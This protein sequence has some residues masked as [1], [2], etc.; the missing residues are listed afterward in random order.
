MQGRGPVGVVGAVD[1][2]RG[3][4]AYHLAPA[5]QADGAPRLLQ[6]LGVDGAVEER[7]DS[8]EGEE[9]VVDLVGAVER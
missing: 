1:H 4:A 2:H 3:M 5:A 7:L 6:H 8:P 9:G